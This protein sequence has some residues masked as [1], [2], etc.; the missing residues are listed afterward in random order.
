MARRYE[1][2]GPET[3]KIILLLSAG[4]VLGLSPDPRA[5]FK[6]INGVIKEWK[7]INRTTLRRSIRRLYK[8]KLVK[9]QHNEDGTHT[10]VLTQDGKKKAL[11]Y[12]IDNLKVN[13]MKSWDRKWRIVL[14][15]I[16]EKLRKARNALRGALKKMEFFEYQKSVFVHP[17]ECRDEIDFVIEYFEMRPYTRYVIAESLDNEKHLKDHFKLS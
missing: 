4:V 13:P 17:Y 3:K 6:V 15:D 5:H 16:P 9:M 10:L 7:E 14:F 12:R 1:D 11:T 2:F 8:S